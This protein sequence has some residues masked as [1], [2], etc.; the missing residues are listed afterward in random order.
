MK[1]VILGCPLTPN[2]VSATIVN[3][4]TNV[5]YCEGT[6]ELHFIE[7]SF[8]SFRLESTLESDEKELYKMQRTNSGSLFPI[9]FYAGKRPSQSE[10]TKEKVDSTDGVEEIDTNSEDSRQRL[11]S[12]SYPENEIRNLA[13]ISESE[14][15]DEHISPTVSLSHPSD[16]KEHRSS[17]GDVFE[18]ESIK[19]RSFSDNNLKKHTMFQDELVTRLTM[20]DTTTRKDE[21]LLVS[22]PGGG[23][24][25][26]LTMKIDSSPEKVPVDP[27]Q[28]EELAT[29]MTVPSKEPFPENGKAGKL[30]TIN[31]NVPE[32]KTAGKGMKDVEEM[33]ARTQ[34]EPQIQIQK[35]EEQ[36]SQNVEIQP[37]YRNDNSKFNNNYKQVSEIL[38]S[39]EQA[40]ID[41]NQEEPT[42]PVRPPR[43][44]DKKLKKSFPVDEGEENTYGA[45]ST[46]LPQNI[47][48]MGNLTD[49]NKVFE[50][51]VD[52]KKNT[53]V[54]SLTNN[55]QRSN[56]L[57]S[58]SDHKGN[59]PYLTQRSQ[60]S[61][62]LND[63][64]LQREQFNT[65]SDGTNRNLKGF[66]R[67]DVDQDYARVYKYQD[68]RRR[69]SDGFAIHKAY[70]DDNML[71]QYST[72]N[73]RRK[74][75]G[76][77]TGAYEKTRYEEFE[78]PIVGYSRPKSECFTDQGRSEGFKDELWRTGQKE[79]SLDHPRRSSHEEVLK[80]D[81]E[82]V[83][84]KSEGFENQQMSG[85][86]TDQ[87]KPDG[88]TGQKEISLDH[89]RRRT[90]HSLPSRGNET[91]HVLP[92]VLLDTSRRRA[93]SGNMRRPQD[94]LDPSR[95]DFRNDTRVDK[96]V[97]PPYRPPPGL[98]KDGASQQGS[99]SNQEN[100]HP[101]AKPNYMPPLPPVT[102][103]PPPYRKPQDFTPA[104]PDPSRPSE[105]PYHPSDSLLKNNLSESQPGY[106]LPSDVTPIAPPRKHR[107]S[108]SSDDTP[109]P[110]TELSPTAPIRKHQSSLV[111]SPEAIAYPPKEASPSAPQQKHQASTP[112]SSENS[113]Y[114]EISPTAPPRRKHR[115]SVSSEDAPTR[116]NYPPPCVPSNVA[117]PHT[118]GEEKY[119]F[120]KTSR[121]N[122]PSH[123]RPS[124][125]PPPRANSQ[126]G[127]EYTLDSTRHDV[128]YGHPQRHFQ[129][130]QPDDDVIAARSYT[131][132]NT[133]SSYYQ[134]SESN[135]YYPPKQ[136]NFEGQSIN[137]RRSGPYEYNKT[138]YG[139][140]KPQS[141]TYRRSEGNEYNLSDSSYPQSSSL[142]YPAD[143]GRNYLSE[144]SSNF[145]PTPAHDHVDG[146]E[147]RPIH[148]R[149]AVDT[150]TR[151]ESPPDEIVVARSV[152]SEPERYSNYPEEFRTDRREA[153]D[154]VPMQNPPE[155]N[156]G[157]YNAERWNGTFAQPNYGNEFDTVIRPKYE[158]YTE[159][160]SVLLPKYEGY[161]ET[162]RTEP[163][164]SDREQSFAEPEFIVA[165]QMSSHEAV[166]DGDVVTRGSR[167]DM[168]SLP[169][170]LR[171][172]MKNKWVS[173]TSDG[174]SDS[175]DSKNKY[176]MTS[177]I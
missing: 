166:S 164:F 118:R 72:A 84:Q 58:R 19:R 56:E 12:R 8:S 21:P 123:S 23:S 148:P 105:V 7:V 177:M 174:S 59:E 73:T 121:S 100:R 102:K 13:R 70:S 108:V 79:I 11:L 3:L 169:G 62:S 95:D 128:P 91:G 41:P 151:D 66:L 129:N 86:F 24:E 107:T 78:T 51:P 81:S 99:Y 34:K 97:P 52:Y 170:A 127:E 64:R 163:N 141:S 43:K 152:T 16:K 38:T 103:E 44:K 88:W 68:D 20:D 9:S 138:E 175:N 17:G 54:S 139:N 153:T 67:G 76:F 47:D 155:I 35:Q 167:E 57:N 115:R 132:Y 120:E 165:K 154:Y 89:P 49:R 101:L 109:Y 45:T 65:E 15:Q 69:K 176:R 145:E 140:F 122:Y 85:R 80:A 157:G 30:A 134:S 50:S 94:D 93:S 63:Y 60:S 27:F 110:P 1:L 90:M 173:N 18:S 160:N 75:E 40:H 74:S 28:G 96:R 31:G 150:I 113:P 42:S 111:R 2:I 144:L 158:G 147:S 36:H 48:G 26:L 10:Q 25:D 22:E 137:Y 53:K 87:R 161:E 159:T 6:C 55:W 71:E 149:S 82:F 5:V 104:Y 146:H 37:A 32:F 131:D 119:T 83:R 61:N 77:T 130:V 172:D 135:D 114:P 117:P 126:Y 133:Q 156:R 46:F 162:N 124:S 136:S 125:L 106:P 33:K 4:S 168:H 116:P 92:E 142:Q 143:A 14:P 112:G 39:E 171:Q 29:F 98:L